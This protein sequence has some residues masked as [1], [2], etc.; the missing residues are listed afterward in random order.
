MKKEKIEFTK[1]ITAEDLGKDWPFTVEKGIIINRDLAII[2]KTEDKKEYALNG[3]AQDRLTKKKIFFRKSIMIKKYLPIIPIWK[4]DKASGEGFYISLSP[5]IK[6][7]LK[8]DPD[9]KVY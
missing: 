5:I 3:I 2:F 7:G 9:C 1:E 6:M 4:K 8:L